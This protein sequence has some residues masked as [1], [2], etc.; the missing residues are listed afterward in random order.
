MQQLKAF[1]W[2]KHSTVTI[3]GEQ[4]ADLLNEISISEDN[5]VN[6]TNLDASTTVKKKRGIRGKIQQSTAENNTEYLQ[7][8]MEHALAYIYMSKG[9]LLDFFSKA[10]I[11]DKDGSLT[12]SAADVLVKGDKLTVVVDKTT[13]LFLSQKYS[14][15]MGEDPISGE[16]N[17]GKFQSG[18]SHVTTSSM[19][20]PAKKAVIQSENRDYVQKVM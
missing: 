14:S 13:K 10:E 9:Q 1:I 2:K 12:A 7:G 18:I 15:L 3:D 6:V 19:N 20:L 11:T 17:Y 8:A 4:K 5:K 16:V